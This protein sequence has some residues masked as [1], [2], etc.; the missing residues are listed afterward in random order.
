MT[1]RHAPIVNQRLADVLSGEPDP[2]EKLAQDQGL[3]MYLVALAGTANL[4]TPRGHLARLACGHFTIT[5][6][7]H[8]AKCERCGEMIRAGFDYEAFRQR[9]AADDF[10]WPDDPLRVIHEGSAGALIG[11]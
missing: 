5:K 4:L 9:G 3:A 2:V 8:K 11:V 10:S 1:T 7:L 6:A